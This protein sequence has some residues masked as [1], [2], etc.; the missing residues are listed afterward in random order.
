MRNAEVALLFLEN[1]AVLP[2]DSPMIIMGDWP[3]E[4]IVNAAGMTG[5]NAVTVLSKLLEQRPLKTISKPELFAKLNTLMFPLHAAAICG[6]KECAEVLLAH[7]AS[8]T[9]T[10]LCCSTNWPR[11]MLW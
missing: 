4:A 3:A 8:A 9:Q 2:K 1:G 5:P 7:G 11:A 6:S 10:C